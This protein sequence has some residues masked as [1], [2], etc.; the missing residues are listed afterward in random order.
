LNSEQGTGKTWI[1]INDVA[2]LWSSG[3]CDGL[4][5]FAPNGVQTNWVRRE[6]PKH[7]PDWVRMRAA[8]WSSTMT[9]QEKKSY[10]AMMKESDSSVLKVL[11]MNW[12][13]L[14]TKRGYEAAEQFCASCTKLMIA[15]D[16]S[17]RAKNPS[18]ATTKALMRLR[19]FSKY[20]RIV[21]G[22][23]ITN[24]PFDAFSQYSF[25]DEHILRTT[26]YFAFKAEYAEMLP[27]ESRMMQGLMRKNGLRRAPQIVARGIDGRPKYR[28]LDKLRELIEPHTFRVLKKDCMDLPEKV[29][30]SVYFDMTPEQRRTYDRAKEEGRLML[31]GEDTPF[32]R[33]VVMGKL[34]QITSGYYLHPDAEEP[35]R[36]EGA[37]NKIK[38]L[39]DRL[40]ELVVEQGQKVIIWARYHV[41]LE[42][43]CAALRTG[44]FEPGADFVEYHGRIKKSDRDDNIDKFEHGDAKIFVGQQQAGGTGITLIA[45]SA[46]IYFSNT[47]SFGDRSQSEDRAHRIGQTKSVTYINI[48]AKDSI[49]ETIVAAL[50]AKKEVSEIIFAFSK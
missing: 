12:E 28:N 19:K 3:D 37:N 15:C 32:N 43:I 10:D 6:I 47:F 44:G 20:R 40:D 11:T 13:A 29:Y 1:I 50:E 45:A 24:A 34:A 5:V 33:L 30:E 8:A 36:I 21:T 31:N 7:M 18:A 41:E 4:L 17:H 16:E 23:P 9:K 46:M 42:D 38:I 35:V 49:D 25:L 26:S 27:A 48:I 14:T 22:T 2:D 39:M